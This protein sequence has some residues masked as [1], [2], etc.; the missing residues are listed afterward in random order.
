MGLAA[1][2]GR[3][4]FHSRTGSTSFLPGDPPRTTW[5]VLGFFFFYSKKN[6]L[7]HKN[8]HSNKLQQIAATSSLL[9]PCLSR[10]RALFCVEA[11]CTDP[12]THVLSFSYLIFFW[13]V[14]SVYLMWSPTPRS[15][16]AYSLLPASVF[17]ISYK[18][19]LFAPLTL[20][21]TSLTQ[22][23]LVFPYHLQCFIQWTVSQP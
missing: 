13:Q 16:S 9:E 1:H 15:P 21:S 12:G 23:C 22:P 18:S 5:A 11:W 19:W 20:F 14:W 10:L 7:Q 6:M 8:K 3:V 2:R 4:E 17:C